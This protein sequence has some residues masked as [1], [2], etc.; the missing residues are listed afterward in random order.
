MKIGILTHYYKSLNYG[1]VL[2]AYALATFLRAQGYEAEQISYAF[3]SNP[4]EPKSAR[5]DAAPGPAGLR[6][7]LLR[8]RNALR[9]KLIEKRREEAYARYKRT[10][11]RE[12]AD[13]FSAFS[14]LVPHSEASWTP[15][16]VEKAAGNYDCLITGSDQVWNFDWFNPAFFLDFP[17]K[18]VCKIAYAASAGRSAFSEKETDYL[19]RV[20]PEFEAVSVRESDLAAVLNELPG[21]Q[22]VVT[23]VDPTML[24]TQAD[25]EAI[26][27]PR[28]IDKP[29]LFCYY[30][31]N[32]EALSR[33]ARD[34]ARKYRLTIAAIPFPGIEYNREDLRFGKYRFDAASPA[35]FLSLIRY[36]DFILTDSFHAAVFSLLFGKPFTVF[37]RGDAPRMGSRLQT[38]TELFG[39]PERFCTVKAEE[40][41]RYVLG[42]KQAQ[43]S[44]PLPRFLEM[45][46][47]SESFLLDSLGKE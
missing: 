4:F 5:R 12:R 13:A 41:Y 33:L 31:H 16:T 18:P 27:A 2:Q 40:R 23:A 10:A 19:R 1:G 34:V 42:L 44:A 7:K 35:D 14:D 45:I 37:P 11:L 28:L 3:S 26:A 8:F 15:E 9:Y 39:C 47:S 43:P 38:L 6:G 29:Y 30:L 36:A 24:L 21:I 32:D 22:N 25:W 17:N 46:K 20:L